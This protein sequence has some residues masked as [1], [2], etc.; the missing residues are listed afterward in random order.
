MQQAPSFC[1]M[2]E[3]LTTSL[4]LDRSERASRR[5]PRDS[6]LQATALSSAWPQ[7]KPTASGPRVSY[8]QASSQQLSVS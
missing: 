4:T 6:A 3:V 2:E 7:I 1:V 8:L 5:L